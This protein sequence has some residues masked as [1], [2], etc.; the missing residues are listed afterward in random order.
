MICSSTGLPKG[1]PVA[2]L[3]LNARK[4]ANSLVDFYGS[5]LIATLRYIKSELPSVSR[6]IRI[7]LTLFRRD[8][9]PVF[10]P[11]GGELPVAITRRAI[12]NSDFK[13]H[14]R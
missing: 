12:N 7:W 8:T 1:L 3:R 5:C 9:G 14:I 2:E 11:A 10:G 4:H 13:N 6:G